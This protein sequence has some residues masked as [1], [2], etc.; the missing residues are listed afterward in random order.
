MPIYTSIIQGQIDVNSPLLGVSQNNPISSPKVEITTSNKPL[1]RGTNFSVEEDNMLVSAWLNTSIDAMHGNELKKERFL[2]KIWQYFYHYS[3]SGTTRTVGSLSSRWGM[4]NRETSRFYGFIA[5]LEAT[6]HSGTTEQDKIENAK[7]M[8]KEKAKKDFPFEHCWHVLKH[9]P[10][11]S[12]PKEYS[13][14]VL[15]PT[16]G[17]I[18]IADGDDVTYKN[19]KKSLRIKAERV[20]LEELRDKERI[21]L[22]ELRD[23]DRVRFKEKRIQMEEERL[24]IEREKLRIKSMIEDE[25]IMSLDTSG[26]SEALKLF[27]EQL[28]E[29]ILA[30]QAS[31][32][33]ILSLGYSVTGSIDGKFDSGY[34]VT[35]NL[36]VDKLKG[37]ERLYLDCFADSPIYPEKVFRRKFQM[38]RYLFLNIISKVETHDPYFVQKRNCGKKLG[39]SSFQKITAA[40]KMLAYGV[41][42]DFMDEYVR[43][44]ET[45]VLQ[46]LE[47]FVTT[48]VDIFSEEYLRKPNNEDI[49]RLLPGSN[50]D[51]N[52]LER[53]PIF[54]KLA[55]AR[56]P[57]VNYSI[58]GYL[59]TLSMYALGG[60]FVDA[61]RM[62]RLVKEKGVRVVARYKKHGS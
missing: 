35:V 38:S 7:A 6:P 48:M 10:K 60:S 14:V 15:P 9:Q 28:Q 58:N 34:P 49:V 26:M 24:R 31:T 59:L 39:L 16:Q 45:T 42:G 18:S 8:Y 12:M 40:L 27:Y 5:A 11:W 32:S 53:S 20:Q 23:R 44:G 46:S 55:Q 57:P 52:V 54:S 56:A 41:T 1:R 4:I 62:R 36:G 3:P 61:T 30:R 19:K 21:R 2:A 50:N 37:H 47:K 25:R 51:I 43:I 17:S 22:E 29:G 33:P 13:R